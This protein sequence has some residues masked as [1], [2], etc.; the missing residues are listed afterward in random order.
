MVFNSMRSCQ[1]LR[2]VRTFTLEIRHPVDFG[3]QLAEVIVKM[4][5]V[6]VHIVIVCMSLASRSLLLSSVTVHSSCQ[7]PHPSTFA[8]GFTQFGTRLNQHHHFQQLY[9]F[10]RFSTSGCWLHLFS[11]FLPSSCS[12]VWG[13]MVSRTPILQICFAD[14]VLKQRLASSQHLV[15]TFLMLRFSSCNRSG[16]QKKISRVDVVS[17]LVLLPTD[18]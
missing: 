6:S 1:V 15:G 2:D 9:H 4:R 14:V 3:V 18:P 7:V 8:S 16:T 12:G 17:F 5:P 10:H 11:K 13:P